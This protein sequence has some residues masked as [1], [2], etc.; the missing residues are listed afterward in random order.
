MA[1]YFL[2]RK[3]QCPGDGYEISTSVCKGRQRAL[4]PKCPVCHHRDKATGTLTEEEIEYTPMDTSTRKV[5]QLS[6]NQDKAINHPDYLK[7]MIYE[8]NIRNNLN[9]YTSEKIGMATVLF[10]K[11]IKDVKNIVVARDIRL[12]SNS[13]KPAP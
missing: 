13:A 11:S 10:L 4:Y 1:K 8:V 6:T 3:R 7:V 2:K 9:E 12:S 5:L